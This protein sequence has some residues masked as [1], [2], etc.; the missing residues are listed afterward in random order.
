MVS[1]TAAHPQMKP[2][3]TLLAFAPMSQVN[4]RS[5]EGRRHACGPDL[6]GQRGQNGLAL[7][8]LVLAVTFLGKLARRLGGLV[9]DTL[10]SRGR[11]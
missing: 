3:L 8:F 6:L 10:H 1:R 7:A 11:T 2:F 9:Q 5:T 4:S